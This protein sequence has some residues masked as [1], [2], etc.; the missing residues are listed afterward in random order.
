MPFT[1][2]FHRVEFYDGS[3][4]HK[5]CTRD[6]LLFVPREGEMLALGPDVFK[7]YSVS[8]NLDHLGSDHEVWHANVILHKMMF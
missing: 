7:V 8:Y 4:D 2:K 5:I 1:V 3:L 6:G